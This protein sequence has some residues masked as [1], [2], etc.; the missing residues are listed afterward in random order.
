MPDP[1]AQAQAQAVQAGTTQIFV[2]PSNLPPPKAL[3]FDDN[4][5][6][7]WKSWK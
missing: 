3:S 5:A 4:L 2:P 6:T 1:P 7:T